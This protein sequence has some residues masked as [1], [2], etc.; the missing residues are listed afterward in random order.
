MDSI[1]TTLKD[2]AITQKAGG[3][4]G[5]SFG[6]IRP[7]GDTVKST[8]REAGGPVEFLRI[9]DRALE[10]IRQGGTRHGANMAVMHVTH[11]DVVEFIEC[12]RREGDIANFN[13][14]VAVT[15]EF[16]YALKHD[17]LHYFVNP[18]TGQI[19]GSVAARDL[20]DRIVDNAWHNGEPGVIFIDEINRHNPTPHVGMMH[21]TNPCGEQPLL[22]NEACNLGS[23]NLSNFVKNE[24][25]DFNRLE[26]VIRLATRFLDNVVDMNRYPTTAIA[27]LCQA[28]RK[29]GLGVMGFADMLIKMKVDYDSDKALEVGGMV[30]R[31]INETATDESSKISEQKGVFPNYYG[32]LWHTT[33]AR[34]VRNA[35]LTTV[36]PTGT[37]SLIA[38][39]SSGIEPRF[40]RNIQKNI[41]GGRLVETINP[42]LDNEYFIDASRVSAEAH[43]RIQ[44][45]FQAHVHAAISKTINLPNNATKEDVRHAYILAHNLRCKS[46]TVYR[47]G[48]RLKQVLVKQTEQP[49]TNG[50]GHALEGAT[51][52]LSC[53]VGGCEG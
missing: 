32:S 52:N 33:H 27:T 48:S 30:M 34:R 53:A 7:K 19:C 6:K 1:F 20:F 41:L 4:C 50:N 42:E 3:G 21:A 46:I 2:A 14:S 8:H 26:G 25:V 40:G 15:D 47:D 43:V 12:K 49:A 51:P 35:T 13:I 31:F 29:I 23:I 10:V 24:E 18:R 28:N 39:C 16:M 38:N 45:T 22:P 11:P 5:F 17:R 36:A 44:A 37:L 9:F